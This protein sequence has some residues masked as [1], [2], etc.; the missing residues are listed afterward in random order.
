MSALPL[1][2]DVCIE[3]KLGWP[4]AVGALNAAALEQTKSLGGAICH[5]STIVMSPEMMSIHSI[6]DFDIKS[7]KYSDEAGSK[8]KPKQERGG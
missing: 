1:K 8:T 2:A 3:L 7:S 6:N 4:R 5:S